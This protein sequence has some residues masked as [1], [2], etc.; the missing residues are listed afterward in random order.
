[1]A[2]NALTRLQ[3]FLSLEEKEILINSSFMVNFNYCPLNCVASLKKIENPQKLALRYLHK[4]Y[5]TLYEDLL[6]KSNFSPMN[7]KRV[8]ALCVE[9]FKTLNSLNPSFMK[10]IFCPRQTDRLA[11]EIN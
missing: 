9:V 4:S 11:R 1:M 8:R 3:N 7:V 6:L 2:I 10:E 5:N